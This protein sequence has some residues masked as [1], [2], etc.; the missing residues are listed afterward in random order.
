M[1]DQRPLVLG[2]AGGTGSGKTTVAQRIVGHFRPGDVCHIQHDAYYRHRPELTDKER[3]AVNYD[4]PD[5]LDNDLLVAHIDALIEGRPI[6]RPN[7]DFA[8]HLRTDEMTEV[9]PVPIV[10]VEG[11]LIFADERLVERM[12]L[13][14]FVDT[15][16]DIRVLRRVRRDMQQRGRAFEDVRQQYYKTV[17]PMHIAFVEPSKSKADL[18]IPEGGSNSVAIGVIVE[19]IRAKLLGREDLQAPYRH[20][21]FVEGLSA[22][23]KA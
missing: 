18:I 2:I 1:S 4:H 21:D 13:K 12:G 17:R 20:D 15:P 14:L 6:Q 11:I 23:R 10:L 5:S 8:T 9:Q 3:Q 7:Y 16:A 19:R 22:K